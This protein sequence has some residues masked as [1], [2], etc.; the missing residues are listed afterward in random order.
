MFF[1]P[2]T[3]NN[4]TYVD[5]GF[6]EN[7][8]S[9]VVLGELEGSESPFE[10]MTDAVKELGCLVSLGTGRATYDYDRPGVVTY[11]KPKGIQSAEDAIGLLK[12]IATDCHKKH[13]KVEAR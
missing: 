1:D 6:G 10:R 13:L 3:V 12:A 7:N 11:V 8:P 9:E 4:I 2:T 5:G